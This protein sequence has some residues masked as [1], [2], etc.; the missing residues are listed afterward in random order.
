M[1]WKYHRVEISDLQSNWMCVFTF[2]MMKNQKKTQAGPLKSGPTKKPVWNCWMIRK[3]QPRSSTSIIRDSLKFCCNI[4][5]I[6]CSKPMS[7]HD[8]ITSYTRELSCLLFIILFCTERGIY[9]RIIYVYVQY[10]EELK[11][12][13]T[14]MWVLKLKNRVQ[15]LN[16]RVLP[17]TDWICRVCICVWPGR[18]GGRDLG[19]FPVHC[20]EWSSFLWPF[21][22]WVTAFLVPILAMRTSI[23]LRRYNVNLNPNPNSVFCSNSNKVSLVVHIAV[24]VLQ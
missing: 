20:P 1:I 3:S 18:G 7:F 5:L 24:S 19:W 13:I 23:L 8:L 11:K 15:I 10:F 12:R 14:M 4:L 2:E 9:T 6:R 16:F 22:R 21:L 17:K